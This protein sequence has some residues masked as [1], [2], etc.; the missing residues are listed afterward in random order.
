MKRY[1]MLM[2]RRLWR[3]GLIVSFVAVTL[4]ACTSSYTPEE[5]IARAKGFQ[6]KGELHSVVI[7]LKNALLQDKGNIEAR[8]MLGTI[9]LD[10]GYG[11]AAEKEFNQAAAFGVSKDAVLA[12]LT[13]ALIFQDKF[14]DVI[15]AKPDLRNLTPEDKGQYY[16][17]LGDAYL[18]SGKTDEAI[19]AYDTALSFDPRASEAGLGKA[20]V[21]GLKGQVDE[22]RKW[23]DK[24]LE[25]EPGFA[26]AWSQLGDLEYFEGRDAESEAAFTKAISLRYNN[27]Y[28]HYQRALL[29]IEMDNSPGSREDIDAL[30]RK[31]PN[32]TL[33]HYLQGLVNFK[34]K[35]FAAAQAEF[36]QTLQKGPDFH[37]AGF[38]LGAA[39][40]YQGHLE[41][42][43]YYLETYRREYPGSTAATKLLAST[44]YRLNDLENAKNIVTPM[45]RKLPDDPF[46]MSL[47]G[48]IYMKES[49][50]REGIAYLQ[51][52][53]KQKPESSQ[54]R[55]QLGLGLMAEGRHIQGV[56]ELEQAVDIAPDMQQ[57]RLLV[58]LVHLQ[59]RQYDKALEAAEGLLDEQPENLTA[60]NLI[61]ATQLA[62]GDEAAARATFERLL[63]VSPGNPSAAHNLAYLEIRDGK[64]ENARQLY[65]QILEQ[66]PGHVRTLLK[67]AEL[68]ESLGNQDE[69]IAW[70][71][72]AMRENPD[73][74]PPRL[75]LARIH[76]GRD[77]PDKALDLFTSSIREANPNHTAL[78]AT[79]GEAQL[80]IGDSSAAVKTFEELARLLPD[81]A[82]VHYLLAKAY[83]ANNNEKQTQAALERALELQPDHALSR[84]AMVRRLAS[85]KQVDEARRMIEALKKQFPENPEILAQDAWL[86]TQERRY[87]DAVNAYAAAY[88]K[89]PSSRLANELA[90]AKLRAGDPGGGIEVLQPWLKDHPDDESAYYTL[91]NLYV[92]ARK[93]E[94]AL[95]AYRRLVEL[96]PNNVVAL[97]NLAWLLRQKD[98]RQALKYAERAYDIDPDSPGVAGTLGVLLL[99]DGQLPRAIRLLHT[100]T[101]KDPGNLDARYNLSLSLARNGDEDQARKILRE[102]LAQDRDFSQMQ[103]A[104]ELLNSLGG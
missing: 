11:A 41:Q 59:S 26:P 77:Q 71:E 33:V 42:A 80:A 47:M 78:L 5:H 102:I 69:G 51:E 64:P 45:L 57:A 34:S 76:L 21:A 75:R 72:R 49:N 14:S 19:E 99:E 9:Y 13:K 98:P 46:L 60:L 7:E 52:L 97:N 48:S 28:D 3:V 6:E 89:A 91:A 32:S 86:A 74:L 79:T 84:L 2:P 15:D 65:Q 87:D 81:M 82:Q 55:S 93:N 70:I 88:A 104:R 96:N 10:M 90:Y 29:R 85:T 61:G 101:E 54:V 53:A 50:M 22:M 37:R 103:K 30:K 20:R 94:Q 58:T 92:A 27:T 35:K 4:A 56:R 16:A 39:H 44:Y 73:S 23:L 8:W 38:Y 25:L 12:P 67:F 43:K 18:F 62:K 100:A 36:E 66:H 95:P 40:Y 17:F 24:V 83:A 63:T 31:S 68:E 1:L